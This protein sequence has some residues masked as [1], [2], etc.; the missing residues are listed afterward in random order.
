MQSTM[1]RL[2]QRRDER[3]DQG[4]FT[5]IELLIVIV[6][7]GILA[8]IVVFAVQNLTGSS[9][10]SACQSDYKT[11]ETALEGYNAQTGAYP[12]AGDTSGPVPATVNATG[13][14]NLTPKLLSAQGT[15]N[16]VGPWLRDYPVNGSHYQI[17]VIEGTSGTPAV[18]DPHAAPTIQ[19]WSN[20]TTPTQLGTTGAGGTQGTINACQAVS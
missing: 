6:I 4:G 7:L 16:P 5:L 11:V 15:T 10:K 9:A 13:A 14:A 19:V 20:A 12:V 17:V 3:G 2:R 18:N 8:A 1:D